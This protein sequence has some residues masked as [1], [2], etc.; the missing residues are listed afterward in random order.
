MTYDN[1]GVLYPSEILGSASP[2]TP[3]TFASRAYCGRFS[4]PKRKND[5]SL[6]V[7]SQSHYK[8]LQVSTSIWFVWKQWFHYTSKSHT[9][10]LTL[11]SIWAICRVKK[12]NFRLSILAAC[13]GQGKISVCSLKGYHVSNRSL[14]TESASIY[15]F[16]RCIHEVP[17]FWWEFKDFWG[18]HWLATGST[19]SPRSF[20][21]GFSFPKK[22]RESV[23][24]LFLM[25]CF[26]RLGYHFVPRSQ[27][28]KTTQ[29]VKKSRFTLL[30]YISYIHRPVFATW[31]S[32]QL[33]V[34]MFAPSNEAPH[35]Q[36]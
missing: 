28:T 14:H 25:A 30:Q 35:K 21:I 31:R 23:A 3:I 6:V 17:T 4:P 11:T 7:A 29:D 12:S 32:G 2:V 9:W 10:Y 5:S 15:C 18:F 20:W 27:E 1:L 26:S 24:N 8:I 16:P 33:L 22:V 36:F 19:I 13:L 34:S